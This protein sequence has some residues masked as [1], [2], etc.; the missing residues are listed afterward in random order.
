[1]APFYRDIAERRQFPQDLDGVIGFGEHIAVG[2]KV[3][4]PGLAHIRTGGRGDSWDSSRRRSSA[5]FA[6]TPQPMFQLALHGLTHI[7]ASIMLRRRA[8]AMR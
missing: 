5:R 3:H 2:T 7:Q 1:M 8:H 4:L 6:I